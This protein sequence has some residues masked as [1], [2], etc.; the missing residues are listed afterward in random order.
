MSF[1]YPCT[2]LKRRVRCGECDG[3]KRKDCGKCVNCLDKKKF[4]GQGRKKQC[5][6]ERRCKNLLPQNKAQLSD[7]PSQ[8][9]DIR[10]TIDPGIPL[11]MLQISVYVHIFIQ[12]LY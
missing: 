2:G 9:D 8:Q 4:N 1:K 3:C 6:I 11:C 10:E 12:H 5:C 7:V